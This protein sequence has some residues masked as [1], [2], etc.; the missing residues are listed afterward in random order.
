MLHGNHRCSIL[1][2][3][4]THL[5]ESI[6][7]SAS[8]QLCCSVRDTLPGFFQCGAVPCSRNMVLGIEE[9]LN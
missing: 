1:V 2:L 4:H 6:R 9:Q 5:N 7:I 3:I 8:E